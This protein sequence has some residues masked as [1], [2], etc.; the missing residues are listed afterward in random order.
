MGLEGNF[1]PSQYVK[2]ALKRVLGFH[3]VLCFK[4]AA[5]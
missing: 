1:P 2:K 3:N 4:E 5:I